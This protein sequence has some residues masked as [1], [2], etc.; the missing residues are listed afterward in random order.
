MISGDASVA[1]NGPKS[2]AARPLRT[3]GRGGAGDLKARRRMR[4][5]IA[6]ERGRTRL[7]VY[8]LWSEGYERN[9]ERGRGRR[10]GSGTFANHRH[11]H[12]YGRTQT[13]ACLFF[14][15]VDRQ[16]VDKTRQTVSPSPSP[17]S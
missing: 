2:I 11:H 17:R 6:C 15:I 13:A 14:A 8:L 3:G 1:G 9:K 4:L 10:L 7:D 5:A 12:Q 16:T